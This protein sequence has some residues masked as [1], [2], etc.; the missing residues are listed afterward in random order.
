MDWT[1][2]TQLLLELEAYLRNWLVWLGRETGLPL[3]GKD[4]ELVAVAIIALIALWIWL[5][6]VRRAFRNRSLLRW[7]VLA[8][9]V[10][11]VWWLPLWL[12]ALLLSSIRR[13]TATPVAGAAAKAASPAMPQALVDVVKTVAALAAKRQAG[14]AIGPWGKHAKPAPAASTGPLQA[15]TAPSQARAASRPAAASA[16]PQATLS[17][18]AR[19]SRLPNRETWIRRRG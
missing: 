19:R 16:A 7:L 6:P 8:L 11:A 15:R 9:N 18:A 2:P 5:W 17:R 3:L 1:D 10:A 4:W 13:S 14:G 12:F